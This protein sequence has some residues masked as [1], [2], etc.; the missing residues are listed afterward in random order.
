MRECLN[1]SPA[2]C[3]LREAMTWAEFDEEFDDEEEEWEEEEWEE[4]EEEF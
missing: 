1:S 3:L 2:P 4:E